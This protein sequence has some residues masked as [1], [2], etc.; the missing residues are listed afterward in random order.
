M[1][2]TFDEELIA[3]AREELGSLDL[4][5]RNRI[6]GHETCK[7][8]GQEGVAHGGFL[9]RLEDGERTCRND[10]EMWSVVEKTTDGNQA[11][12]SNAMPKSLPGSSDDAMGKVES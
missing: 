1:Q 12:S 3:L 7:G 4:N 5:R 2:R 9:R 11:M 10:E 8:R 6:D